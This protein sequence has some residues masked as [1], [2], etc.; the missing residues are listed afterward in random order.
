MVLAEC[1]AKFPGLSFD[2]VIIKTTGDKLQNA[3]WLT[4]R[5]G[6][7]AHSAA[8]A[9]AARPFHQGAGRRLAQ[10]RADLAVQLE[11]P[12]HRFARG[13]R[14]AGVAGMRA[15]IR[16]FSFIVLTTASSQDEAPD[17]PPG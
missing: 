1:R 15:D 14:L 5:R 16:T 9:I 13:L 12:A 17:F 4:R 7:S 10:G 3:A 8:A 2:L 11:G 6:G